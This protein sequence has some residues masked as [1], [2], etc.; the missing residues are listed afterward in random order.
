MKCVFQIFVYEKDVCSF[1]ET[2]GHENLIS[3][4]ANIN[5]PEEPYVVFYWDAQISLS[6]L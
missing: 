1:I 6:G 4:V 2:L 3:V 5:N